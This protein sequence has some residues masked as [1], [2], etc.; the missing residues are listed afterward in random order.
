MDFKKEEVCYLKNVYATLIKDE[1]N[2]TRLSGFSIKKI[3]A[4]AEIYEVEFPASYVE[5]LRMVGKENSFFLGTH[6]D[7]TVLPKL[8]KHAENMV[9]NFNPKMKLDDN[10]LVFWVGQGISF[11]FFKLDSGDNPSIYG[12]LEGQISNDFIEINKNLDGF[13]SEFINREHPFR[14]IEINK[15][16]FPEFFGLLKEEN[17]I[18]FR[19][20]GIK[21][22][23]TIAKKLLEHK[24]DK[25]KIESYSYGEIKR[26]EKFLNIKFPKS[27]REYLLI[28]GENSSVLKTNKY[29]LYDILRMRELANQLLIGAKMK[30]SETD[31]IFWIDSPIQF[32]FFNLEDGDNPPVY[33]FTK[34][35][36]SSHFIRIS[37]NLDEFLYKIFNEENPF[38][39]IRVGP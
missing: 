10:D 11:A 39:K 29:G 6:Y 32:A 37:E 13:L 19:N 2:K 30:L 36:A 22:L 17:I 8:K 18:Q 28:F 15:S 35:Q 23:T 1:K 38:K 21:Y 24:I 26:V 12:Y 14:K 3:K 5:F 20:D 33:G 4:Y 9:L 25:I 34:S 31:F 7:L 16:L 27:Y